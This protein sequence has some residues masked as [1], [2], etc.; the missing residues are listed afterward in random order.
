MCFVLPD[1]VPARRT[2]LRQVYEW[3]ASHRNFSVAWSDGESVGVLVPAFPSRIGQLVADVTI[4]K[5]ELEI[6]FVESN[7][8]WSGERLSWDKKWQDRL[9]ALIA[10]QVSEI[11]GYYEKHPEIEKRL[12]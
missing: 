7:A 9:E 4:D 8:D 11:A 1:V 5:E 6:N 10:K 3:A 2:K 12:H